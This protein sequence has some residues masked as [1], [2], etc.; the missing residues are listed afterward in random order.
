M[1]PPGIFLKKG[2]FVGFVVYINQHEKRSLAEKAANRQVSTVKV[3]FA[4]VDLDK[5][6]PEKEYVIMEE[7]IRA[8]LAATG[9]WNP[10]YEQKRLVP[11]AMAAVF[12]RWEALSGEELLPGTI[13]AGQAFRYLQ[14]LHWGDKVILR[15]KVVEKTEKR[16]LKF[17]VREVQ[18]RLETGEP[19]IV[20]RITVILPE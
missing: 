17:V 18:A 10:L 3:T 8:Y 9:D 14:P 19:A 7:K 20:S 16:G 6:Y 11:P 2:F 5:V 13:H 15:G 4:E 12:T 1:R